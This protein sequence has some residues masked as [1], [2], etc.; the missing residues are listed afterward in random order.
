MGQEET[1][2][3]TT[4]QQQDSGLGAHTSSPPSARPGSRKALRGQPLDK[5]PAAGM[6]LSQFG[7]AAGFRSPQGTRGAAAERP[8]GAGD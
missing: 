7:V 4:S 3:C 1:S 5:H 2:L 6:L 8:K